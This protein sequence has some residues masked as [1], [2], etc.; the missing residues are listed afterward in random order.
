LQAERRQRR[1]R[2]AFDGGSTRLTAPLPGTRKTGV[3]F[4][5]VRKVRQAERCFCGTEFREQPVQSEGSF[6]IGGTG[7]AAYKAA[8]P[9]LHR[10]D[11]GASGY[12]T[13]TGWHFTVLPTRA[14]PD[15]EHHM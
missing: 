11:F 13:A 7:E 3:Y 12:C 15:M 14:S 9:L 10:G 8:K 2:P 6:R 5:R 1:W 4:N